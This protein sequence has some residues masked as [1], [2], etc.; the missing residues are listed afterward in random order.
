MRIFKFLSSMVVSACFFYFAVAEAGD[1][2]EV[3]KTKAV[4]IAYSSP[5]STYS[6]AY[7]ACQK[8]WKQEIASI[9]FDRPSFSVEIL[10][11]SKG[12]KRASVLCVSRKYIND[13]VKK[14]ARR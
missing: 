8:H 3:I 11:V 12:L 14:V 13:D 7:K 4:N 9:A 6:R 1:L 2:R 5:I 10:T